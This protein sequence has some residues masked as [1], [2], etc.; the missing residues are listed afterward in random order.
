MKEV[1]IVSAVRS[2]VGKGK[3]DGALANMHAVDLSA[4]LM[5]A[6]IDRA[7]IDPGVIDDV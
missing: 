4:H 3:K 1:V 6:A 7:Y 5:R 2:P